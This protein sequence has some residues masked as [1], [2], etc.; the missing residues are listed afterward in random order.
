MSLDGISLLLLAALWVVFLWNPLMRTMRSIAFLAL[1]SVVF[2][3]STYL[4]GQLAPW[5]QSVAVASLA[6]VLL[7][8][9]GPFRALPHED[10]DFIRA[11]DDLNEQLDTAAREFEENPSQRQQWRQSLWGA[12]TRL[13]SLSPPSEDWA[14]ARAE[15]LA[16]L[17]RRIEL[18]D[19]AGI[20]E[21]ELR[22]F[23][24]QKERAH[25]LIAAARAKRMRFWCL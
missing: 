17:R 3:A 9:N 15:V 18:L 22:E 19:Q 5:V 23:T 11:L 10:Q 13:T 24:A 4:P 8:W 25:Q 7:F 1:I 2:L 21:E 12:M 20:S 14:E 16:L 6:L